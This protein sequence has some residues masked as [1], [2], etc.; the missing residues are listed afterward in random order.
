MYN[1]AF[2]AC[3][4]AT[5]INNKIFVVHGGLPR[6]DSKIADLHTINRHITEV[7]YEHPDHCILADLIWSDPE[8]YLQGR[9]PNTR[10]GAGQ[11]FGPDVLETFLKINGFTTVVRS[12]EAKDEGYEFMW[13]D[14][15]I[16]VFSASN[17]CGTQGNDGAVL[18]YESSLERKII[19]W[20]LSDH[21]DLAKAG[22]HGRFN[23]RGTLQN[24]RRDSVKGIL[25]T[26]LAKLIENNRLELI[27][28]FETVAKKGIV[29]RVQWANSLR[30]VLKVKVPFLL[31]QNMLGVPS[32]G[33]NAKLKGPID[34]MQW[35]IHF[36]TKRYNTTAGEGQGDSKSES[37]TR[38]K[39]MEKASKLDRYL[40]QQMTSSEKKKPSN[41]EKFLANHV[42]KITSLFRYFDFDG[43]GKVTEL[44]FKNGL[45]SISEVYAEEFTQKEV[46]DLVERVMGN[47]SEIKIEEFQARIT[48]QHP[49]LFAAVTSSPPKMPSQTDASSSTPK[50]KLRERKARTKTL[51]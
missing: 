17:Y 14:Q 15:L 1:E 40:K 47:N 30:K 8:E 39:M 18:V 10:R 29:S 44:D 51:G 2:A 12:H 43:D 35:L 27:D 36:N 26:K 4:L 13:D 49:K 3:P 20:N 38:E 9:V 34:Y 7:D 37:V 33:V 6:V 28:E 11:L 22:V 42:T 41:L 25:V 32:Y 31:F 45:Q 21:T 48:K 5:V 24:A 46:D 16:T 23:M 50:K 19:T